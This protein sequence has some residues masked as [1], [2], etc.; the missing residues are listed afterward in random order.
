MKTLRAIAAVVAV[1]V[2]AVASYEG[3]ARPF[4]QNWGTQGDEATRALPGD[5]IVQPAAW[6]ATRAISIA[7]PA[8]TVWAWV[9]QLGQ[10]RGGFYSFRHLENLFGSEMPDVRSLDPTL[11]HWAVGDPLR[12]YPATKAGGAMVATLKEME[13]GRYLA[14]EGHA[15]FGSGSWTLVIVP[16]G[17]DQT[18]LL[19]RD[20]T[21]AGMTP[22]QALMTRALMQPIHFVMEQRMLRGIKAIAEGRRIS[23]AG[24]DVL[25]ALWLLTGMVGIAAAVVALRRR[26]FWAGLAVLFG[27]ALLFQ[28]LTFMQPDPIVGTILLC[29]LLMALVPFRGLTSAPSPP[30]PVTA[31]RVSSHSRMPG[32]GL[33]ACVASVV[34]YGLGDLVSGLL[35]HG[36]SYKDQ[37]I[38]E[39]TAFGS[40][41]RLLM[42]AAILIHGLLLLV[43]GVG[44]WRA[45]DR[46][47]LRSVGVLLMLAGVIGFPTHTVF[48]MSSRWMTAGF[49]DTMHAMLSLTFSL[50]VFAAVVLSAVAFSGWFRLYA[51]ATIPVLVGFGAASSVAIQGIA[52]NSTPWAGAFERINAY[53]YFAWL[54][55][56]AVIMTRRSVQRGRRH[57]DMETEDQGSDWV[58]HLAQARS[59]RVHA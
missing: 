14:F 27:C 59:K 42:V 30:E 19:V 57:A 56:L 15:A 20:R 16:E 3:I 25:T 6:Q 21:A 9:A 11:Q 35:Y 10:D 26:R 46:R 51:I 1:L 7:A 8:A 47:S 40:P 13:V 29:A 18:R 22:S 39:L 45:A 36:Y 33:I 23:T 32:R 4:I 34:V 28:V 37:W 53:A 52:Q 58:G 24:N 31:V 48:A 54:I 38:S 41:V 5:D 17:P 50:I 12:M 2:L 44:I 55:V 43:F 49:N